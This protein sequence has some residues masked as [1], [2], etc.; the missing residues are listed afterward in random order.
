MAALG[1]VS[2]HEETRYEARLNHSTVTRFLHSV[3]Y[4]NLL[5]VVEAL[6]GFRGGKPIRILDIGCG[7]AHAFGLLDPL[8]A[9][10]YVGV[11]MRQKLCAVARDRFGDR[12]NFRA[13]RN[14]I[15][16]RFD[17]I[18]QVDLVI[19]LETLEHIPEDQVAVLIEHIGRAEIDG[20][21]CTVPNEIGPAIAIKNLG[22]AMI[23]YR[24]HREYSWQDT[25]HS[26][27]YRLD[28]V[29]PHGTGHKGFDWRALQRVITAHLDIQAVHRSPYGWV[30]RA[31]SPSIGFYCTPRPRLNSPSG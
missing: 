27:T 25:F 24:R 26:A 23:G 17:L 11:E 4:K 2:G 16:N 18:D 3:R 10:D 12:P 14:I 20:F 8:F 28:K 15:G 29:A 19:A 6:S 31:V 1:P 22:S 30:P 5:G 9:I 21:Y 7:S 13:V